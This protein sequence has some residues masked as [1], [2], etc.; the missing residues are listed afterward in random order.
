MRNS[1]KLKVVGKKRNSW[2]ISPYKYI[3]NIF[4]RVTSWENYQSLQELNKRIQEYEVASVTKF[5]VWT[6]DK[7]FGKIGG[8]IYI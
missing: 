6:S 8:L 4:F 2:E 3:E 5:S 1:A 7:N